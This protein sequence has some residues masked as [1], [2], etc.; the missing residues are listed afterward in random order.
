MSKPLTA[1]Q[2]NF[3]KRYCNPKSETYNNA[4]QS[5][6]KA[7]YAHNTSNNADS[8]ILGNSG[9][10]QAISRYMAKNDEKIVHDRNISLKNL[11]AAYKMAKKQKNPAGM[12]AAER[13]KNAI[14]SLHSSTL[15]TDD[16]PAPTLTPDEVE[17]YKQVAKAVLSPPKLAKSG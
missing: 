11:Q 13:E 12:I 16:I 6:I 5:A 9:V 8:L 4:Y 14:S 1:K 15:H 3:V 2:S 17:T 7:G 10:K